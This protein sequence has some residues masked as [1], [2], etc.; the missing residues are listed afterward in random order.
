MRTLLSQRRLHKSKK[1]SKKSRRRK[2][3][4]SNRRKSRCKSYPSLHAKSRRKSNFYKNSHMQLITMG[5]AYI[6][7]SS[8]RTIQVQ[9]HHHPPLA[10]VQYNYK[11][12]T[13]TPSAEEERWRLQLY[14]MMLLGGSM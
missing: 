6:P 2:S 14:R 4:R 7:S 10:A 12:T 3:R 11:R 8:S 5:K 13:T 1:Y 9:T